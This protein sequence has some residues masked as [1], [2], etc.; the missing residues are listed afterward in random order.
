MT[1]TTTGVRPNQTGPNV[2]Y[3][4]PDRS[5]DQP[6]DRSMKQ[7]SSIFLYTQR[8]LIRILKL[9]ETV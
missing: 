4:D 6:I 2:S 5:I 7:P 9:D 3:I 1:E 8:I